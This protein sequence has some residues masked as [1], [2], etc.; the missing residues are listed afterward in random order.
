[1]H[2]VP[3]SVVSSWHT[4]P[5]RCPCPQLCSLVRC[6]CLS[7]HGQLRGGRPCPLRSP[8]RHVAC[9]KW[10]ALY[11]S[12][13]CR[14]TGNQKLCVKS[15]GLN[16]PRDRQ[17]RRQKDRKADKIEEKGGGGED[18]KKFRFLELSGLEVG[19]WQELTHEGAIA[20]FNRAPQRPTCHHHHTMKN[21][22]LLAHKPH[23][24]WVTGCN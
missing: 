11:W 18:N 21:K 2:K 3:D 23:F 14:W 6:S 22:D 24:L 12:H 1:M 16:E 19:R 15:W 5:E 8:Q 9:L 13:T 7:A 17:M 10:A 20:Q 4:F